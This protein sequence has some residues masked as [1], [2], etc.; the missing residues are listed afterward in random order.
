MKN[1]C[2][3]KKN[4]YKWTTILII[5][6][7][8]FPFHAAAESTVEQLV[9]FT[10]QNNSRVSQTFQQTILPQ[11]KKLALEFELPVK[12]IEVG[13][14]GV[15]SEIKITPLIVYQ[16]HLGR[17]IYQGRTTTLTRIR[18]FIRTS[19][20]VPQGKNPL[21]RKNTPIL[22]MGRSRV[23]APLKVASVTGTKPQGYQDQIFRQRALE[24][25]YKGFQNFQPL[26]SISLGR[27]D[28]GF[29]MDFYPWVSSD[30]T[31]FLSFAVFSQFHCK[32]P[33]F[34]TRE[35]PLVGPWKNR[36]ELFQKAAR[37]LENIVLEK[38]KDDQAGD[39][40]NPIASSL[41]ITNWKDL[42]LPLPPPPKKRTEN[43][44][45]SEV[46]LSWVLAPQKTDHPPIVLFRFPAPLDNYAGEATKGVGK[47][48]LPKNRHPAGAT[49]YVE[50]DPNS[51]TMGQSD[52]DKV[53]HSSLMLNTK[54]YPVSR[55]VIHSGEGEEQ[56]ITY[57]TLTPVLFRGNL[58]IKGKTIP[59]ATAMEIEPILNDVGEPI[60]ILKGGFKVDLNDLQISGP[61]GPEESNHTLLF[62]VNFRLI[63][64]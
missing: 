20:Y 21:I 50:I 60:L 47:F 30:N 56:K 33:I 26:E 62:D 3:W 57:G 58:E 8:M 18:N 19:R 2:L 40:F 29:Y 55:F 25:I 36:E 4:V 10:Q 45:N 39:G 11:I 7:S 61:D 54:K 38:I 17:S 59:H 41:P 6:A 42:G 64:K 12:T 52:L 31:L 28:R 23:W 14:D 16:N 43:V 46:P 44:V 63:P 1:S 48:Q 22:K 27:A 51:V 34:H 9:I 15:P 32:E 24:N 35:N 5:W 53:I 37:L 49:G 13:P